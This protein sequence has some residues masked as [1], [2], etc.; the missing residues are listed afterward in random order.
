MPT[1][2]SQYDSPLGPLILSTEG[3]ALVALDFA[4]RPRR[5]L[6]LPPPE[7]TRA[8]VAYFGGDLA[9]LD[10]L[11]VK[12]DGTPFQ[13]RVWA[14]LRRIPAGQTWSYAQLA[15]AVGN[16]KA[17]RAVGT[18]NGRN[19]VAIV[20]PCHRVIATGGK[21]GGYGGGLHRKEWLLKHERALMA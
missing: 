20:V 9:A 10:L 17:T 16:P 5:D 12:L 1:T 4:A 15:R 21:L 13:Q 19:P 6:P 8:L 3:D 14:A 7:V 11:A 2:L 18:A